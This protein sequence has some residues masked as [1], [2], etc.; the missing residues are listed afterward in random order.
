MRVLQFTRFNPELDASKLIEFLTSE[1]W[2]FHGQEKPQENSIKKG[3]ENGFYS[4]NGNETFWVKMA[5]EEIGIIRIF[6]LEDPTCLFDIRLKKKNRGRGLGLLCV[7]WLTDHI[8]TT[9]THM[10]RIEAHTR[11][12]NFAMRKTLHNCQY[13][14][15]A[16]HRLAWPQGDKLYDSVGYAIVRDDWKNSTVTLINDDFAY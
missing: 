13:V 4:G 10:I 7:K 16:Y 1:T 15:E 12:D 2:E 9:Y 3:I 14:K 6:D 8:F 11:E 5:N